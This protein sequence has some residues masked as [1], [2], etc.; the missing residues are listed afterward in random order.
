MIAAE[1]PELRAAL[2]SL[3]SLPKPSRRLRARRPHQEKTPRLR[4]EV[5]PPLQVV[6]IVTLHQLHLSPCFCVLRPCLPPLPLCCR[7]WL[8]TAQIGS[9]ANIP[10]TCGGLP[11]RPGVPTCATDNNCKRLQ[12]RESRASP[13]FLSHAEAAEVCPRQRA[14]PYYIITTQPQRDP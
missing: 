12:L 10:I 11:S 4:T 3:C 7:L 13:R 14:S 6:E 1:G 9:V 2:E 5:D 8:P